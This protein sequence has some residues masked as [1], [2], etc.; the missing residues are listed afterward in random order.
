MQKI[1]FNINSGSNFNI[2]TNLYGN[3]ILFKKD[4]KMKDIILPVNIKHNFL[5][6]TTYSKL[7]EHKNDK[8]FE[9]EITPK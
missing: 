5:H 1:V 7:N 4:F 2:I 9:Y 3:L 6:K 8:I